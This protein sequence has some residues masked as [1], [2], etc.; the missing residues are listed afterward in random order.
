MME[1][2]K[3]FF[4][5][6]HDYVGWYLLQLALS[7]GKMLPCWG[8]LSGDLSLEKRDSTPYTNNYHKY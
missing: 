2:I 5:Q 6:C 8:W 3:K 1:N 4:R 7:N